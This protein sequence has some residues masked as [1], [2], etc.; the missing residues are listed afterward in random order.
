MNIR[1]PAI[2]ATHG[3]PLFGSGSGDPEPQ[4]ATCRPSGISATG[5]ALI[6]RGS[7]RLVLLTATRPRMS[8]ALAAIGVT[9][10]TAIATAA[11]Q[12][13]EWVSEMAIAVL[14]H[15][16]RTAVELDPRR[17]AADHLYLAQWH[18]GA[19]RLDHGFLCREPCG[20][21]PAGPRAT[22]RIRQLALGEEPLRQ[23]RSPFERTFD[24]LDLDQVDADGGS[25]RP[26]AYLRPRTALNSALSLL[27]P[28]PVT[29]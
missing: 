20:E 19:Q 14:R 6:R 10:L 24:A 12:S 21:V 29:T 1:Q 11:A 13:R 8:Y 5:S 16:C 9:Q 4:I 28:E 3:L 7:V 2:T 26:R 22:S 25:H 18:A 17:L 15:L 23:P 27:E